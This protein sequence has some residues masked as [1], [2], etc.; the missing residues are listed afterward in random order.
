MVYYMEM[1]SGNEWKKIAYYSVMPQ[2]RCHKKLNRLCAPLGIRTYDLAVASWVLCHYVIGTWKI[3]TLRVTVSVDTL[4]GT[5]KTH[6]SILLAFFI[7]IHALAFYSVIPP[8]RCHKK[9]KNLYTPSGVRTHDLTVARRLLC[10]YAIRTWILAILGVIVSDHLSFGTIKSHVSMFDD[11]KQKKNSVALRTNFWIV[12]NIVL[13]QCGANKKLFYVSP[14]SAS[15][16]N[17]YM[18]TNHS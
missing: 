5:I 10:H 16:P 17:R 7:I 18:A 6:V 14:T 1:T 2:K 3:A 4:L 13:W 12:H 11:V 15:Y 9:I 8:L